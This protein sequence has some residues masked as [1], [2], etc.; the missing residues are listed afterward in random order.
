MTTSPLT[1]AAWQPFAGSL[2][3]FRESHEALGHLADQIFDELDERRRELEA[4]ES[5]LRQDVE[6]FSHK[7]AEL[8]RQREQLLSD[9][10][11]SADV[12]SLQQ[13]DAL[14]A[15]LTQCQTDLTETRGQL[16]RCQADLSATSSELAECRAA[17]QNAQAELAALHSGL[18]KSQN[19]LSS[20]RSELTATAAHLSEQCA[21]TVQHAK[22][23]Q[24]LRD[25]LHHVQLEHQRIEL[26]WQ[27][28]QAEL[29]EAGQDRQA[30]DEFRKEFAAVQQDAANLR[31]ELAATAARLAQ[32]CNETIAHSQAEQ[33]LRDQLHE[34]QLERQRVELRLEQALAE[35]TQAADAHGANSALSNQLT[36]AQAELSTVRAELTATAARLAEQCAETTAHAKTE[37]N[38]R[39]QLHE[40]QLERQ[41]VDL[42]LEQ[43]L[44][45]LTQATD[46]SGASAALGNQLAASQAELSTVRAELT[47]TAARLAEQCAAAIEYE[48]SEQNLRQRLHELELAAQRDATALEQAQAALAAASNQDSGRAELQSQLDAK[49]AELAQLREQ[50]ASADGPAVALRQELN[51]AEL[52]R[53]SLE[54][55]LENV[56][57]RAV[58][59]SDNLA[60]QKR[61]ANEDRTHWSNELKEMRRVLERQAEL[62]SQRDSRAG[63]AHSSADSPAGSNNTS[64][65]S[66]QSNPTKQTPSTDDAVLG[67]VMA[68]FENL[69]KDRLRRRSKS[70]S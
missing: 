34:L 2:G 15:E 30:A 46:E 12:A 18:E 24:Q 8:N 10:Q 53:R 31:A 60:A 59:L 58:E 38:L 68:Q 22:S 52:E 65:P 17:L 40:L 5:R 43:A 61:Q 23:E 9:N 27:Q 36:S 69:Q 35:L 55:E 44:A 7:A 42:R 56:R 49:A 13:F 3:D 45:E 21:E 50:L 63:A 37:Q 16:E 51:D 62:L 47:S 19:E 64:R 4:Q 20:M 14:S 29:A 25:Q 66:A 54:M 67:S 70:S 26:L 33:T 48:K 41:R 32:Q 1:I 28:T 39:E 11:F 6:Q 57:A